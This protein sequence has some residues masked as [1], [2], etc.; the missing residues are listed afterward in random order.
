MAYGRKPKRK[1]I[2]DEESGVPP[3]EEQVEKMTQQAKN[4]IE[5]WLSSASKSR[6]EL[7][8]KVRNKGITVEVANKVLDSYEE[9]GYIDDKAFAEQFVYSKVTYDRYG[10][11]T[12]GFKLKEKGISG[13][14]IEEVLAEI[15]DEAEEEQAKELAL[16]RAYSTR[17]VTDKYKRVQQIAGYLARRGYNGGLAF[18]LAKEAIEET[19]AEADLD[20]LN[21]EE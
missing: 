6:H 8:T 14:I 10:K 16:R 13:D 12:I 7:F 17:R 11:R 9:I 5:Y 4:V 1:P 2:Y 18:K 3:T 21:F 15:D 20:D 19:D